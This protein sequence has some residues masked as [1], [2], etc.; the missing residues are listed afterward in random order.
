MDLYRHLFVTGEF[1]DREK[2]LG[3]LTLEQINHVAPGVPHS[4]FAELW[5]LTRWQNIVVF[6]DDDLAR[7]WQKG[8]DF[9]SAPATSLQQWDELLESYRAGV[10]KALEWGADEE[11][12]AAETEPGYTMAAN[13]AGLAIHSAHHF[14]K[15]LSLRQHMGA[16]HT[17]A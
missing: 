10:A 1:A 5:H 15:I 17:E 4:I 16:W 8:E 6:D 12:L 9:P 13:L 2:I 3:G 7:T 11:K 14:G